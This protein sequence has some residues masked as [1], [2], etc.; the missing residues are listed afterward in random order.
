V[1]SLLPQLVLNVLLTLP[2]YIVLRPLFARRRL[3]TAITREVE[4]VG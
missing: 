1:D 3:A 2:L 4:L